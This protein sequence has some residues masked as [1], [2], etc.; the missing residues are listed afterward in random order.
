MT[1]YYPSEHYDANYRRQVFPL[2][3]AF[4][5][6][7]NYDDKQRQK[8]YGVSEQDFIVVKNIDDSQVVILTMSWNYY[9]KTKQMDLAYAL[10]E[11]ANAH[12]KIVWSIINGDFGIKLPY[13]QENLI[14][15]RQSGYLSNNQK[16]H[17]G[18]PSLIN[19]Y[20][21]DN[22]LEENTL[23]VEY[24]ERPIVGFCG[25]ANA[26]KKNALIEIVKQLFRNLRNKFGSN[27]SE[28]QKIISAAYLRASLLNELEQSASVNCNFIKRKKYRAGI[29]LKLKENHQTTKA[30]FNNILDSQYVLCVRGAGNFS[31]RFYETLMMGR[32]PLYI[33]TDG[34]IPLA[35]VIDWKQHVVWVDYKDRHQMSDIL[36]DFHKKLNQEKLQDLCLQN[37][38]LWLEK[39]TLNGFFETQKQKIG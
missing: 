18:F 31:A 36:L 7:S 1:F 10:V 34:Y 8:D 12:G 6:S 38:K 23:N 25:L 11:K 21:K 37:R 39:L 35:D 5:K 13:Y 3:K 26:S 22:R 17:K 29:D 9:S 15:F 19:D 14:V 4:I 2:L 30:F 16:G 27:D 24:N 28:S 33:H 32:I 20:L